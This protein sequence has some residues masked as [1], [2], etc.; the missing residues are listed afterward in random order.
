MKN[1]KIWLDSSGRIGEFLDAQPGVVKTGAREWRSGG[2]VV[3]IFPMK[4]MGAD[5]SAPPRVLII[6]YHESEAR[7]G[8]PSFADR[9]LKLLG[10][11]K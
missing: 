5:K 2:G 6:E 1:A 10:G 3:R 7:G 8:R 9:L 11:R 4:R